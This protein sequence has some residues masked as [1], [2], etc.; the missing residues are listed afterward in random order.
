MWFQAGYSQEILNFNKE[1][2]IGGVIPVGKELKS[3]YNQGISTELRISK[4]FKE[5]VIVKPYINYSFLA[6]Y[7][8]E[9]QLENIHFLSAGLN[10]DISL[11]ICSSF[12]IYAGPSIYCSH[13]FDYLDWADRN[14]LD[15]KS[16]KVTFSGNIVS[17]DLRTGMQ[18]K[19]IILEFT[20]KPYIAEPTYHN[21]YFENLRENELYQL[22][23]V[24]YKKFDLSSYSIT[25]GLK[26]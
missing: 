12:N 6:N 26:L 3:V 8:N 13:Y 24:N 22:Y 1:I 15:Y 16:E 21:A 5:F 14:I 4:S 10:I 7:P 25:L 20:Y 23:K 11:K 9:N 17:F 2:L 19:R 18:F